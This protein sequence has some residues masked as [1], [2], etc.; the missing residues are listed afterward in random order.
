M[1]KRLARFGVPLIAAAFLG[2]WALLVYC[3]VWRP[4]PLGLALNFDTGQIAVVNTSPGGA[5][6]RAGIRPGDRLTAIDGHPIAGHLDWMTVEANLE[7]GR[8]ARFSVERDGAVSTA[9]ITPELAS[10]SSW[11]LQHG[12][13]L[14]VVRMTQLVTLLLALLVVTKRSR[15]SRAVVGAAFL[16]TIGVFSL[17]LPYRFASIWRAL[18]PRRQLCCCGFRS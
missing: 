9:A 18:P 11:R 10:W 1:N 6:Q 4:A 5:G 8:T 13:E 3:E 16:A 14:L 15:D 2:Y 12:P 7:L 17:T